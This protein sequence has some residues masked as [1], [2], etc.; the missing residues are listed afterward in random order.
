MLRLLSIDDDEEILQ[1]NKIYFSEHQYRIDT[2]CNAAEALFLLN[3]E[4]YDCILLDIALTDD[5]GCDFCRRIRQTS[6]TPIIF[7]TN[8]CQ[9]QT[10]AEAFE[11]GGDDYITKPYSFRELQLRIDARCK[12]PASGEFQ[13]LKFGPLIINLK[14]RQVTVNGQLVRLTSSEYDILRLLATHRNTP[15]TQ[16]EIYTRIWHAP[17]LGDAHTVQ[18]H[19][20]QLRKK[21]NALC[22]DK[23]FIRTAWGK[24]Y[25]FVDN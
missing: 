23:T 16:G 2:A 25:L 20:G 3:K 5:N 9:E 8:F 18:V 4:D 24:G 11:S 21:L 10:L 7:V 22:P 14:L 17:D 12:K 13:M 1:A 19:I 15:F 6:D